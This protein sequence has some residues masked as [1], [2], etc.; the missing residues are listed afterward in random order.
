MSEPNTRSHHLQEQT[1]ERARDDEQM[2]EPTPLR[3]PHAA[4][5]HGA[6]AHNPSLVLTAVKDTPAEQQRHDGSAASSTH[7]DLNQIIARARDDIKR[8]RDEL[9]RHEAQ[10]AD[11]VH[12]RDDLQQHYTHL[13]DNFVEAVHMAAD[14]EVRQ[15]AHNLR[16]EPGRIPAL[17]TP[18]QESIITWSDKQQAE[19]EAVLRQKLDIVEQQA[20]LIRQD[21]LAEQEALQAEREKLDQDRHTM[22][23]QFKARET[24]LRV[25]WVAKAWAT[26]AVMFLVLPALQVDLLLQKA[27]GWNLIIIPTTICLTLTAVINLV[28][29]RARPVQKKAK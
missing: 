23:A 28:R 6:L 2:P 8:L 15:A 7:R 3:P 25:R 18:I 5:R 19:R 22:L 10:M 29:A 27:S 20:A 14:E 26:A 9:T 17:F 1:E 11:I 13:Y 4:A 12:E 16:A 21:I 24:G